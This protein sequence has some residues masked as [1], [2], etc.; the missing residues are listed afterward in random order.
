M[1]IR[2]L[3]VVIMSSLLMAGCASQMR[4]G[5]SEMASQMSISDHSDPPHVWWQ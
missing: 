3:A 5:T 2:T 1:R 4:P